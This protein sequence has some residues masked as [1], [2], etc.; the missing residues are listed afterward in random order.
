MNISDV[1][2]IS[3]AQKLA[4]KTLGAV[5]T[6]DEIRPAE[7]RPPAP[8]TAAPTTLVPSAL[9][10]PV[11][12]PAEVTDFV[13]RETELTLVQQRLADPTCR[14]LTITGMGGVGKSRLALR[15]A[16]LLADRLTTTQAPQ[17]PDGIY[18][19]PLAALEPH[20]QL[21][22]LLAT[23]VAATLGISLAGATTPTTQLLQALAEKDLLLRPLSTNCCNKPRPSSCW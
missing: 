17:F 12:L 2:G 4:L 7:N 10:V 13:G 8:T 6:A 16:H 21:E 5:E 15:I 22:H 14:L 23:T 3:E 11:T 18:Y 1:T 19:V 9:P 20:P